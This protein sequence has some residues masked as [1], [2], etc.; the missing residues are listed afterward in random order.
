MKEFI[1]YTAIIGV[2]S[3]CI[4]SCNLDVI[5]PDAIS[6]ENF[7]KTEKDAWYA[8]NTSYSNMGGVD[9]AD[10]IATDN[11]H[12]QKPW[13]GNFE[14][15]QQNGIGPSTPFGSYWFDPIRIA[16][17]FLANVD[18]CDMDDAIRDRM[19]AEARFFRAFAYL[20]LTQYY[21]KVAIITTVLDYDAP[22]VARNSVEDVRTF[23]LGELEAVAGILPESYSG[24]F[25]NEGGRITS[26]GAHALRARAALYFGNYVEA[27]KSAAKVIGSGKYS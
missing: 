11:G 17:T 5:P 16:N 4:T 8:L 6:S 21:G 12:S 27:E 23:I 3:A 7:W 20:D 2:I 22:N 13:E 1:K 15:V 19:K 14:L 26:M 9:V 10:E 18:K 25:L 24:G